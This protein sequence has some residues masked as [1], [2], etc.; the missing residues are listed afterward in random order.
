MRPLIS[1]LLGD[2]QLPDLSKPGGRY[3]ADDLDQVVRLQAALGE[4]GEYRFA[5]F[6][7]HRRLLDDLRRDPPAFVLNFCDIQGGGGKQSEGGER[8]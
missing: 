6:D 5:Y 1:V 4:L 8:T 3:T 7:D 2:P